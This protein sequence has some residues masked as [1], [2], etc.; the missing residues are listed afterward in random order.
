MPYVA[1]IQTVDLLY[2]EES[3]GKGC[4]EYCEMRN[5][6]CLP[7][8]GNP[9]IFYKK[10]DLNH[11]F[12]RLVLGSNRRLD[13]HTFLFQPDLVNRFKRQPV[14]F[15]FTRG[16]LTGV[17]HFSDYNKDLVDNY[18]FNQFAKY[19]RGLRE[20]LKRNRLDNESMKTF[21]EGKSAE[22]GEV[23]KFYL[24][25][26]N[27]YKSTLKK[28]ENAKDFQ[29]DYLDDLIGL[30]EFHH[31]IELDDDVVDLRN[32]VMHV[33]PLIEMKDAHTDD[34][35]FTRDSFERFF[36][37][38]LTL[39]RDSKRVYN[40]IAFSKDTLPESDSTPH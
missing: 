3:N 5:I 38:V 29:L 33:H 9:S 10:N 17:V 30:L 24:K 35:I 1:D 18:L 15:V 26:L 11:G 23:G 13:G 28:R 39:L 12:D 8:I 16:E 36:G 25:R 37:H 14:Q 20:L 6:D 4:F 40:R 27:R 34:Y 19:E 32:M 2:Y 7:A 31:I 21:F 22:P